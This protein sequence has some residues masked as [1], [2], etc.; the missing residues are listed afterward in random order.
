MKVALFLKDEKIEKT[1]IE[2]LP[3]LI[4]YLGEK[5]AVEM[6]KDIIIRKDINY[7]ALWL[8]NKKIEEIYVADIDP[9]V[10]KLF[11]KLN[12]TVKKHEEMKKNPMLRTFIL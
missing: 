5:K 2:V 8:L 10:R 9:L 7:L 4:L 1:D 11:E 3:I 6:E 12:V